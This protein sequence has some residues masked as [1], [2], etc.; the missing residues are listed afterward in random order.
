MLARNP[1]ID[2][3]CRQIAELE[4]TLRRLNEEE[5]AACREEILRLELELGDLVLRERGITLDLQHIRGGAVDPR[6]VPPPT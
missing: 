6:D 3:L 1:H 2:R 4:D 5:L